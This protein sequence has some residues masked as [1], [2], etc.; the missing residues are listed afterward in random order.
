MN[1]TEAS[2]LYVEDDVLGRE[3]MRMIMENVIGAADTYVFEDS[4]N[5]MERLRAL[6]R[7]PDLIMLDIH[8]KP[9]D[10]VELLSMIRADADYRHTRVI[11]LTASVMNEEVDELRSSGFDGAIAK[12]LDIAIFPSLIARVLNGIPTWH[13][14]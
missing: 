8:I 13:I 6:P 4:A 14:A 11:A 7:K 2:Y 3:I 9:Y 5:F 10:G 12:P 1:M